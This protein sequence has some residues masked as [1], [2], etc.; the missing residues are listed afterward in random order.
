MD[1]IATEM[2]SS[3]KGLIKIGLLRRV[4]AISSAS[5]LEYEPKF[6]GIGN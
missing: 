1:K 3:K 6:N 5:F 2:S 4:I